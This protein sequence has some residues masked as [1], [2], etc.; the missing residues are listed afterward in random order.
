[1]YD[2]AFQHRAL[3]HYFSVLVKVLH[4]ALPWC[5]EGS[6]CSHVTFPTASITT[7]ASL[8]AQRPSTTTVLDSNTMQCTPPP[9]LLLTPFT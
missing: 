3:E 8:H 1:M 9:H 6:H 2:P 7:F 5:T 4:T